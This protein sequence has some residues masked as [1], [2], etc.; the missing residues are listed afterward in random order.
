MNIKYFLLG[1][2]FIIFGIYTMYKNKFY[3]FSKKDMRYATK[4]QV[5]LSGFLFMLL[6]TALIIN[7]FF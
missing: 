6:G 2:F 1:I 7:V 3:K 5:F 4:F